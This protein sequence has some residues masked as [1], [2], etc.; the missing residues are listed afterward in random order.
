MNK[1]QREPSAE[2]YGVLLYIGYEQ[3]FAQVCAS[4]IL[5]SSFARWSYIR[6]S[7]S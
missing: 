2:L 3:Q 5:P 1:A 4:A 7:L 6:L